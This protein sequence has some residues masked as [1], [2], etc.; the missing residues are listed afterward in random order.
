MA[1]HVHSDIHG[2]VSER[3]KVAG[4]RYTTKRR[5]II[6][7]LAGVGQP[8][9]IADLL[10]RKSDLPQFGRARGVGCGFQ[11]GDYR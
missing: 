11:S 3:L 6:D 7:L 8:M 10:E 1:T 5:A 9:S 4:Q 2:E